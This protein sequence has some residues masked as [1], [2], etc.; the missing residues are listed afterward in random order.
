GGVLPPAGVAGT[1]PSERRTFLCR[2]LS[3]GGRMTLH[4]P[5]RA[6][7]SQG[8]PA[9][10]SYPL[11]P[12]PCPSSA[13]SDSAPAPPPTAG[14]SASSASRAASAASLAATPRGSRTE[15]GTG[16]AG[17]IRYSLPARDGRRQSQRGLRGDAASPHPRAAP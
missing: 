12:A 16:A 11:P 17:T 1:R 6:G 4:P 9:R 3:K 7:S 15:D 2:P 8:F 13:S 14:S 10:S 5:E